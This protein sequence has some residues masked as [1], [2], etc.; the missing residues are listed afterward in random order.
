MVLYREQ[1]GLTSAVDLSSTN[2]SVSLI[3]EWLN[4]PRVNLWIGMFP[5]GPHSLLSIQSN[6]VL[7]AVNLYDQPTDIAEFP[8]P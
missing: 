8:I 4:P 7:D 1:P 6:N 2:L 5:S 3:S